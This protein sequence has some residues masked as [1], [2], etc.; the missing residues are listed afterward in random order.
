MNSNIEIRNNFEFN[1]LFINILIKTERNEIVI[2]NN[3]LSDVKNKITKYS[4]DKN[5]LFEVILLFCQVSFIT[6]SRKKIS[7]KTVF[8]P[9]KNNIM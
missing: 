9:H 3:K 7:H 2:E 1:N 8:A 5:F 4:K 6:L